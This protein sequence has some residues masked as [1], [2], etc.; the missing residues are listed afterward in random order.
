MKNL[1]DGAIY[2][3]MSKLTSVDKEYPDKLLEQMEEILGY[4][5]IAVDLNA[6][7]KNFEYM[8]D[9]RVFIVETV[10]ADFCK[11]CGDL[12]NENHRCEH[13]E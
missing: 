7:I 2:A 10:A 1:S 5:N 8:D 13:V 6:K 4:I 3:L 12:T 11:D 9:L